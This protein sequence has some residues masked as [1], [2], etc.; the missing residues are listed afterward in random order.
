MAL[1]AGLDTGADADF[2][3]V[4]LPVDST[5]DTVLTGRRFEALENFFRTFAVR[6]GDRMWKP[7][8][9]SSSL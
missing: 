8:R 7:M 2:R 3:G 6:P 4:G 5:L 9:A 1:D